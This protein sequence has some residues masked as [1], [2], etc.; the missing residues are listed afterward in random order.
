MSWQNTG[1]RTLRGAKKS[2]SAA[3]EQTGRTMAD[4]AELQAMV[5][6][7][8]IR[9]EPTSLASNPAKTTREEKYD[10]IELSRN[11]MLV[12]LENFSEHIIK[13]LAPGLAQFVIAAP[14]K[15]TTALTAIAGIP[16]ELGQYVVGLGLPRAHGWKI[17]RLTDGLITGAKFFFNKAEVLIRQQAPA[18]LVN[19]LLVHEN[20]ETKVR[21]GSMDVT[22]VRDEIHRVAE[23]FGLDADTLVLLLKTA[24][25]VK[26]TGKMELASNLETKVESVGPV[27]VTSNASVKTSAPS[28]VLTDGA[29]GTITMSGGFIALNPVVPQAPEVAV[30]VPPVVS[31]TAS[32]GI[33][34]PEMINQYTGM[35][36]HGADAT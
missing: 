18:Y 14:G 34:T 11:R 8:A 2:V 27:K 17:Q 36:Y 13:D 21:S 30:P 3:T 22:L 12:H 35:A 9:A 5:F 7:N 16:A 4:N 28:H 15:L 25:T 32:T 6:A 26:T 33:P 1:L 19:A 10:L 23:T 20:Y 24:A 29:G 31:L